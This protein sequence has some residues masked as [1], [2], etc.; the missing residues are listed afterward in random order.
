MWLEQQRSEGNFMVGNYGTAAAKGVSSNGALLSH[1]PSAD[2][3]TGKFAIGLLS[4]EFIVRKAAPEAC[5]A[6]TKEFSGGNA[7]ELDESGRI[8]SPCGFFCGLRHHAE[9]ELL[10]SVV[11]IRDFLRKRRIALIQVQSFPGLDRE[12]FSVLTSD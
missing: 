10:E 11:P 6:A 9:K 12:I 2:K 5:I 1:Q 7:E 4:H 3:A 8:S